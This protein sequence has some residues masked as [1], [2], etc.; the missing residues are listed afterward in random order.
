M[1]VLPPGWLTITLAVGA[2]ISLSRDRTLGPLPAAV[3]I[4]LAL[5]YDR[6][7]DIGVLRILG[8][9]LR[10]QDA[11]IG[12][13]F[14]AALPSILAVPSSHVTKVLG[15]FV[16]VAVGSLVVGVVAEHDL[17]DVLR[18][19]R[20]WGLYAGGLLFAGQPRLRPRIVRAV[21]IGAA[22]FSVLIILAA[23][24]P[25]FDGGIK[26]RALAFDSGQLR[27]QF[28]TTVFLLIPVSFWSV[29]LVRGHTP[30]PSAAW[31]ML[32]LV[33]AGLSLTRTFIAV[34]LGVAL[35]SAVLA[36][37]AVDRGGLV[38]ALRVGG[39]VAMAIIAL[40]LSVAINAAGVRLQSFGSPT[41]TEAG[42]SPL[43]AASPAEFATQSA[44]T[45]IE[46]TPSLGALA[47]QTS[48]PV[49]PL[50]SPSPRPSP[51]PLGPLTRLAPDLDA[52]VSSLGGRFDSYRNALSLIEQSPLI[53]HGLGQ[54]IEVDYRF[55][56]GAFDTPGQLPSVDNAYLTMA[57][58]AG[59][60]G[61]VVFVWC[62]ALPVLSMAAGPAR[63]SRPYLLPAWL[64][65]LALTLT[66]S[67]AV[68][69]HGP[70]TLGLL[71]VAMA[72]WPRPRGPQPGTDSELLGDERQASSRAELGQS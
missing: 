8:V 60:V 23:V 17:R 42:G 67:F 3:L 9:P 20:W 66:Q 38:Q 64:G 54:L 59:V 57:V 53:G 37:R 72:M 40:G 13:A 24:L 45:S 65:I 69:G 47:P 29:R 7:A 28:G 5:P 12:L 25:A 26:A 27:M 21:V 2:W 55:G 1:I 68:T 49:G 41:A 43:V 10:P 19:A 63:R 61:V 56:A 58:K 16:L 30:V 4:V 34:V 46:P 70:F 39:I 18:D 15:L 62:F 6:A 22:A 33:G 31:L 14:A 51:T 71:L 36:V 35:L 44:G 32:F 52:L 11:V 50:E 48:P